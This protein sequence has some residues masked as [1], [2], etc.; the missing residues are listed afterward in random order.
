M[1]EDNPFAFGIVSSTAPLSNI[2]G[3][4]FF[5]DIPKA[6]PKPKLKTPI[7]EDELDKHRQIRMQDWRE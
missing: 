5:P 1:P 7:L 2:M 3:Y 4:H 6:T